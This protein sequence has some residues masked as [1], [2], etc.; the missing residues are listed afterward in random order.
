MA[1]IGTAVSGL[2]E[3]SFC[4]LEDELATLASHLYAGT[5]RW[6]ELVAEVDRRGELSYAKVRALTRIADADNEAELLELASHATASQLE[7]A[8]RAYRRVTM[9][10]AAAAQAAAYFVWSW[11]DDGSLVFKGQLA[12]DDGAVFLQ[13]LNAARDALREQQQDA[14]S[15]S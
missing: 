2:A 10:E 15:G 14:E 11:G 4:E 3:L 5:C 12:P 9:D 7:R 8:V 6:L 1:A 13:A